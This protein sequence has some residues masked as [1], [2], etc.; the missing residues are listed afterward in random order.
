MSINPA[1]VVGARPNFM[2]AAAI[3][4]AADIAGLP[5]RIVRV[6][7]HQGIMADDIEKELGLPQPDA[8]IKLDNSVLGGLVRRSVPLIRKH[9]EKWHTNVVVVVGDADVT[10]AGALAGVTT[11][12]PIVHVEAGLRAFDLLMPEE[13]NRI[14]VDALSSMHLVTERS[15]I[16]N[17]EEEGLVGV[18]VGNTMV[19]TLICS[20][21]TDTTPSKDSY[22]LA[23]IHRPF[24]VDHPYDLISTLSSLVE[25]SSLLHIKF[26]VHPRTRMAM[27]KTGA[28]SILRSSDISI[29]PPLPYKEFARIMRGARVVLTDSGGIQEETTFLGIPCL[30]LRD[31]TERT[32]TTTAGTNHLVG[33]CGRMLTTTLR[34]I[35]NGPVRMKCSIDM[36][37]GHAGD[38]I[39]SLLQTVEE[40]HG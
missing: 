17:L 5:I 29:L 32:I 25:A 11:K 34:E 36:W 24:N 14:I 27:D 37:D 38:R 3:L 22:A 26:S 40:D 35:L 19:D 12:I 23:T 8:I 13:R 2:K 15:A 7:Q 10:L 28:L 30:T 18:L 4:R 39:V 6:A 16:R 33:R 20:G 1:I 21:G 9:L 31:S